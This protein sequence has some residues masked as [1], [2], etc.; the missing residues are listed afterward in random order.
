[1]FTGP[2]GVGRQVNLTSPT[3]LPSLPLPADAAPWKTNAATATDDPAHWWPGY[4][5]PVYSEMYAQHRAA[6]AEGLRLTGPLAE[7]TA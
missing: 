7:V 2:I 6:L 5:E 4:H 1:M 3:G